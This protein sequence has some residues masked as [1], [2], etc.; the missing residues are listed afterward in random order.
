V[1]RPKAAFEAATGPLLTLLVVAAIVA[2]VCVL[3]HLRHVTVAANA[4]APPPGANFSFASCVVGAPV[5]G[6]RGAFGGAFLCPASASG[7]GSAPACECDM[8]SCAMSGLGAVEVAAPAKRT[9]ASARFGPPRL[10]T[11]WGPSKYFRSGIAM[12]SVSDPGPRVDVRS[13]GPRMIAS[14]G[15]TTCWY[16]RNWPDVGRGM[17][18]SEVPVE[19]S[20]IDEAD[21]ERLLSTSRAIKVVGGLML[22][23][24]GCWLLSLILKGIQT[25]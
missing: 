3:H 25:D 17:P 5:A 13:W 21:A 15:T 19:L 14:A 9:A 18:W 2:Q 11:V 7:V 24:L 20:R 16:V 10:L 23:C 12:Q 6:P 8:S 1:H 4:A 22:G